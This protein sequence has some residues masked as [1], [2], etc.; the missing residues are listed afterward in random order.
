M[1]RAA[2]LAGLVDEYVSEGA[3]A[4]RKPALA[5]QRCR[6]NREGRGKAAPWFACEARQRRRR[7]QAACQ[8]SRPV[9]Q[10]RPARASYAGGGLPSS[11]TC[12]A[13]GGDH[14]S[15]PLGALG[16]AKHAGGLVKGAVRQDIALCLHAQAGRWRRGRGAR[17]RRGRGEDGAARLAAPA[18][19]GQGR[20]AGRQARGWDGREEGARRTVNGGRRGSFSRS[21]SL[22]P[23]PAAARALASRSAE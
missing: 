8:R 6:G 1:Q 19:A 22:G 14:H 21:T 17:S 12:R 11:V 16:H 10:R 18:A 15:P 5:Q 3:G 20:A 4:L 9:Q 7:P 23:R 2:C 13:A